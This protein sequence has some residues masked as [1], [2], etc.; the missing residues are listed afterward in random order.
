MHMPNSPLCV[1]FAF[2]L[3][4][5]VSVLWRAALVCV[6][7]L[8]LFKTSQHMQIGVGPHECVVGLCGQVQ[9]VQLILS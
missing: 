3:G 5:R 6:F 2:H 9:G 4:F 8:G 1:S 7:H